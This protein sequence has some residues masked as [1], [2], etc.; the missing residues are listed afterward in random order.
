MSDVQPEDFEQVTPKWA[1]DEDGYCVCC[2]NGWWKFHMPD[3][4][5]ADIMDSA[6]W[7]HNP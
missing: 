5:L 1:Y 6:R 4:E 2:G 7:E 3:C